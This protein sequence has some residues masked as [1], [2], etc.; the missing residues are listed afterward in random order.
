MTFLTEICEHNRSD[1]MG[2]D[3]PLCI[4]CNIFRYIRLN[5]IK[6]HLQDDDDED[7]ASVSVL[8]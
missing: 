7:A 6:V 8:L 2:K 4:Y 3:A 1:N 5:K